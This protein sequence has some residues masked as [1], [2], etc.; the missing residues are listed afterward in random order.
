[1]PT[2]SSADPGRNQSD[3]NAQVLRLWEFIRKRDPAVSQERV[4]A[5]VQELKISGDEEVKVF[6]R[7]LRQAL[8]R[9]GIRIKHSGALH[10]AALLIDGKG[11]FESRRQNSLFHTLK[12]VDLAVGEF[13][14]VDWHEAGRRMLAACETWIEK[15]PSTRVFHLSATTGWLALSAV[16]VGEKGGDGQFATI[17]IA[18]VTPLINDKRW[19][20]GAGPAFEY[21]RRHLELAAIAVLDGLA[22]LQGCGREM[23]LAEPLTTDP[24]DAHNSELVLMREDDPI[25]FGGYEIVRGDELAC[26]GQFDLAV[27]GRAG[28]IAVDDDGGWVCERGRFAWMLVTLKPKEFVPGLIQHHLGP[29]EAGRLLR[30]YHLA[31]RLIGQTL[32]TQRG[33]KHLAYL[34]DPRDAYRVNRHALLLAMKEAGLTWKSYCAEIGEGDQELGKKLPLGALMQLVT[35]LAS[36]DP[37]AFF[38]RPTRSELTR[39]DDDAVL[40]ALMPR[41]CHVRYRVCDGLPDEVRADLREAVA[42]FRT[43]ILLRLGAFGLESSEPLPDL[44][45]A[46]D[47]EELMAKLEKWGLQAYVGV[48]P[49]FMP[50]PSEAKATLPTDSWPYAFGHSLYLDIDVREAETSLA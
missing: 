45:Y 11:W 14:V 29:R 39:A 43:S 15:N 31:K 17:P 2:A 12:V 47:G 33:G 35:K 4:L 5:V 37:N 40:R 32:P 13:P 7:G 27:E 38:A 20:V 46:G 21:L 24:S 36:K 28:A 50:L 42:E 19:L 41:V 49:H 1:M 18:L 44:V 22:T 34:S 8:G 6:A 16:D 25:N 3:L 30:R 48:M 10:A 26:W 9:H 23:W